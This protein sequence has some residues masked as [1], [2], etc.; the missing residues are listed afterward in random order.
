L[1]TPVVTLLLLVTGII[2][3][4]GG[5]GNRNPPPV[6]PPSNLTYGQVSVTATV[7]QSITPDVPAVTG[8]VGSYTVSPTLP[9]GLTLN[10]S[11][12]VISGIPTVVSASA[13]Y[14]VT[15]S[16]AGGSTTAT[17]Q[18]TVNVPPPTGL[19][20]SQ[21]AIA[22][23]VNAAIT[24]D[25]PTVTGTV[26]SYT[27][28]PTLPT[29]LTLNSSTGVISGAPTVVSSTASYTLT[30]SNAGGSTTAT[31]QIAVSLPPP[32]SDLSYSAG[33]IDAATNQAITPDVPTVTGT[34]SLYTVS[35]ALP[36]G[37]TLS[38]S[39][40]A[41]SGTPTA[42]APLTSYTVTASNAGGGASATIL[43]SV[44]VLL[45]APTAFAYPQTFIGTYVGREIT[46]DIPGT[47]GTITTYTVSPALPTGLTLDPSTGIISG[48]PTAPAAQATYVI[49]GSNSGGSVAAAVSPTITITPAPIVLLQLSISTLRNTLNFAN[50]RVFSDYLGFWI[51][52][53]YTSGAILA[54]GDGGIA[55]AMAGSTLAI[56]IPGGIE[57]R[58]SSDGHVLSTIVSPGY[59]RDQ[60]GVLQEQDSWQLASDGSYI[61]VETQSGL[62]VYTPGGALVFSIPGNYFISLH[63]Y[64]YTF[65]AA[66]G[67]VQIAN[68]PAGPNA[69]ETIS[70]PGGVS[71]VSPP[72]LEPFSGWFTD[73][74]GF[75]T[76]SAEAPMSLFVY[77]I[78]GVP[79]GS[80][81][82]GYPSSYGGVGGWVWASDGETSVSIYRPGGWWTPDLTLSNL[83]RY[84]ISG[85]T[86][87]AV[88][89]SSTAISIIDLSGRTLSE[90]DYTLPPPIN[91][92][93]SPI[94]LGPFAAASNTQWVLGFD[95]GL[96]LDGASLSS[97]SPRFLGNGMLGIAGGTGTAA[98]ATGSGQIYYFDPAD[99]TPEGVISLTSGRMQLSSD[100]TVLADFS[101][102]GTLLNIYSLLSGTV[103]NTF[104]YSSTASPESLVSFTLSGSGTIL[105]QVV[106]PI[107]GS[108]SML[109]VA[110]VSGGPSILSLTSS[111]SSSMLLSPDGTL[112]AVNIPN[113]N[114]YSPQTATIYQNG[115][116]ITTIWG[117]A[118]GWI[119]NGRLLVN[120]YGFVMPFFNHPSYTGCAIYSPTGTILGIP[121]LP[122]LGGIQPVTSDTVYAPGQNVIYSLTTGQA[123]WTNPYTGSSS[124]GAIAGPYV[125]FESEGRV[126]AVK[127]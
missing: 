8:T 31:I 102:D 49:T 44:T 12:G 124:G 115:Q 117:T 37:L 69:I 111:P 20:Y 112:V 27:V 94:D 4:C 67:Q 70:V 86:L 6:V 2:Q 59:Y 95:N 99:T 90:T 50:S 43:I 62:F 120:Y 74:G 47:A 96:I 52:W 87:A 28:S 78:S 48:I 13:T 45:P 60:Y 14:T 80:V 25:A 38:S 33:V 106:S 121:P 71:T 97:T 101:Q 58:S 88:N 122:E 9:A 72:Y 30:A 83:D 39:T 7:N 77:S 110:P 34:V 17:V 119:D 51:L 61:S 100:G 81:P 116:P 35:P 65:F 46:P 125:V 57:V 98:I 66:P 68:G 26:S 18:I 91:N 105:G 16:N 73:G 23:T 24:P 11:T 104:S 53:D 82:G 29:G 79:F 64:P 42:L 84:F 108:N 36:V 103:T 32:P 76:V 22:A 21:T 85:T 127:Y 54:S 1:N 93:S 75:F 63:P 41:I 109:Q 3:G 19:S 118:V 113:G 56:G 92:A 107:N 55:S 40:G 126:I 15:A 10:S 114:F 5:G 89:R 123:T